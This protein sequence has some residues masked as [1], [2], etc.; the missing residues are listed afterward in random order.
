VIRFCLNDIFASLGFQRFAAYAVKIT[1]DAE[2]DL[3]DD[4]SQSLVK[5]LARSLKQRREGATV[6]FTYD[7]ALPVDFLKLLVKKLEVSPDDAMIPGQ[8]Y[9]NFRDFIRFPDAGA[10]RLRYRPLR[11]VVHPAFARGGRILDVMKTRDVLLHYPYHTFDHFIDLLRE[12][13]ID[14]DVVSIK[15]TIYRAAKNSSVVNALVN[16]A[17]NGKT[18]T[19]VLELQARFDEEANLDWGQQLQEEGVHVIYGVPGLKVHAKLCQIT[20]IEADRKRRYAVVGTGNFNEDTARLYSDHALFTVDPRITKEVSKVFKFCESN[21]ARGHF[22][23]LWVSPFATRSRLRKLIRDEMQLAREGRGGRIRIKLNNLTDPEV[24]RDLY[25]ASQGGVPVQLL[26]RSMFSLVPGLPGC[27][28]RIEAKSIV[29]RFLEHSRILIFG[30]GAR[31]QY[32]L[33]S[34]DLMAR[35]L[36]QRLEVVCPV[37]DEALRAEL[38]TYFDV[39][40]RDTV[41][42]RLLDPHLENRRPEGGPRLRSQL[43]LYRWLMRQAR[44]QTSPLSPPAQV[45]ARPA[46]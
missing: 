32:F 15:L 25:R 38:E 41:K 7:S 40:W 21:F 42:A 44:P 28:D 39:Q 13:S 6:R 26:V 16:A 29:D 37:Y 2:L 45:P 4:V 1:R 19:V 35:N 9:H 23:H 20:R 10:S 46:A 34:A 18:V 36:D 27:S 12:G 5:K 17:R 24:I 3:D 30:E 8:R 22:R 11:P 33:S 31:A 43:A 14:P